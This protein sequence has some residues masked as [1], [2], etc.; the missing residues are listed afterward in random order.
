MQRCR[1]AGFTLIELLIGLT[2]LGFITTLLFATFRTSGQHWLNVEQRLDE[3]SRTLAVRRFVRQTIEQARVYRFPLAQPQRVAFLGEK[4]RLRLVADLPA[5]GQGGGMRL[6]EFAL[7]RESAATRL[8]F[9]QADISTKDKDM[10][11]LDHAEVFSRT[12]GDLSPVSAFEYFGAREDGVNAV[13]EWGER[14]EHPN[15]LPL[16]VRLRPGDPEHGAWPDLVIAL[17]LGASAG[18]E[19]DPFF[20]RCFR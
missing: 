20:R 19:W 13:A 1:R 6:M 17:R 15:R 9:R 14:W 16:L 4:E 5:Q 8:V 2:L 3:T 18:C 10:A 7:E 11:A 12:L